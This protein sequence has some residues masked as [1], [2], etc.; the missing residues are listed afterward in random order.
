MAKKVIIIIIIIIIIVIII[1]S[2]KPQVP[3]TIKL[4]KTFFISTL[5]SKISTQHQW[6]VEQLT[7]DIY[8]DSTDTWSAEYRP[9]IG[10]VSAD[11]R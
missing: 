1:F 5:K 7:T 4:D 11:Y 2:S 10:K 6:I 3:P 9:C 8:R